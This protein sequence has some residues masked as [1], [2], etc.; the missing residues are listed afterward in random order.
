MNFG[1][2]T[3]VDDL[4]K[5]IAT[6]AVYPNP[7]TDV[8][9]LAFDLLEAAPVQVSVYDM[10]GRLQMQLPLENLLAGSHQKQLEVR[11]LP[12]GIYLVN[13]ASGNQRVMR[14]LRLAK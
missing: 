2:A 4:G 3:A 10:L 13:I 12:D 1:N 11:H 8:V 14:K 6:L 5:N 7:A 9:N